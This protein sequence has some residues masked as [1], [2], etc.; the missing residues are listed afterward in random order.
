MNIGADRKT[1][2][3]S[4]A[5]AVGVPFLFYREGRKYGNTVKEDIQ[6]NRVVFIQLL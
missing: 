4:T 2:D 6:A 3:T 1:G 5:K